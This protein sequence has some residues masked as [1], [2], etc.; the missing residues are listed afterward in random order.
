[1][2]LTNKELLCIIII[3]VFGSP[4]SPPAN[5][6]L[7]LA[8]ERITNSGRFP[9]QNDVTAAMASALIRAKSATSSPAARGSKRTK[10]RHR[11]TGS[12][13][14]LQNLTGQK[15]QALTKQLA[16]LHLQVLHVACVFE[17]LPY[18]IRRHYNLLI[19]TRMLKS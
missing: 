14:S 7:S 18:S 9:G 15:H 10:Y 16:D 11:R 2:L 3:I 12:G 6:M 17:A 4:D 13:T 1:M 19:D 5:G 8:L